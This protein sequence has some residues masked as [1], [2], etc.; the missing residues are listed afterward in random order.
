MPK[1]VKRFMNFII[2]LGAGYLVICLLM[3]LFQRSMMYFPSKDLAAPSSYGLDM[4]E[5]KL[6]AADGVKLTAW[7]KP[8]ANGKT[9]IYY[10]GNASNLGGRA[11][12]Y[13]NYTS[14]G[15][16]L[17]ALSWRGYGTSEGSP[18]QEGL[19]EDARAAVKF[20]IGK[21]IKENEM[22]FYGE[23]LG[24]GVAVQMATE[25]NP[26]ALILEAPYTSTAEVGQSYYPI[27]PVK[28]LLRDN[29]DSLSKIKKVSAALLILHG[30][31]D[32][33]IPLE[34]G[35]KL[36]DAANYPKRIVV[37]PN[38]GHSDDNSAEVTK[39]MQEF[40]ADL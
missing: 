23:S 19:Y 28:L 26:K 21:N 39:I 14:A 24:T 36:F 32:K 8:S 35:K 37:F 10:H 25:F 18:S 29:Y 31:S 4:E 15:F 34:F 22:V 40:I 38:H 17:L 3:F 13:A 6:V 11:G 5:V 16:G 20:L 27:F 9:I 30:D 1:M 12:K 7:Y 33:V 2:V